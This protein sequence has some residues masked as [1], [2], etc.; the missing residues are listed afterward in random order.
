MKLE[1]QE[2]I[3]KYL[4]DLHYW[5]DLHDRIEFVRKILN[6]T[7]EERKKKE[8][9]QIKGEVNPK[10]REAIDKIAKNFRKVIEENEYSWYKKTVEYYIEKYGEVIT[11][12]QRKG[13]QLP[14]IINKVY[15]KLSSVYSV[16]VDIKLDP[17]WK[18][19]LKK[20]AISYS[21]QVIQSFKFKMYDKI[22][23]LISDIDKPFEVDVTG[24]GIKSNNIHFNFNDGSRFSI[25]NQ[26][27]SKMSN[28]GTFFYSYPTTFH[29]AYL[30]NNEKIPNPNE[31]T[32]KKAFNDYFEELDKY[33][34]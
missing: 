24:G 12:K 31:Y 23:G 9:Q 21:H 11:Y 29:D 15:K 28:R 4:S 5:V 18:E 32:V 14:N 7:A 16:Y 33:N 17:N 13:K 20:I 1:E 27:V 19:I 22:G 2:I 8:L 30:P 26:I 34:I 6:P 10:I 25:K 3:D